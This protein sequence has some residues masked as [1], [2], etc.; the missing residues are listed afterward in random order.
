MPD[1]SC[2][3]QSRHTASIE[4]L[5]VIFRA[6]TNVCRLLADFVAKVGSGRGLAALSLCGLALIRRSRRLYATLTLRN[7]R[8][9]SGRRL[10][11]QRRVPSQ[12][13]SDG[14]QN[15][16][17]LG[18]SRAAQSEPT[19]LQ[20]ALQVCE[21]HLDLFAPIACGAKLA[22]ENGATTLRYYQGTNYAR[23][24]TPAVVGTAAAPNK[25]G[26]LVLRQPTE[27]IQGRF[28]RI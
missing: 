15:K 28:L 22:S 1:G 4:L 12:V 2:N 7:A 20:D 3:R 27:I 19:E 23:A 9:L 6:P 26:P 24:A 8:S 14:G 11:G 5:A 25:V 17:I 16:L 21:P 18:T 13:L 10:C